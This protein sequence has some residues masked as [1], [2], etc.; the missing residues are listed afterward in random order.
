[1]STI[2]P[3]RILDNEVVTVS[4]TDT[5]KTCEHW[6]IHGKY[7]G[8]QVTKI[9]AITP[10][11]DKPATHQVLSTC[12]TRAPIKYVC[13]EHAAPFSR[14]SGSICIWCKHRCPRGVCYHRLISPL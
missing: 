11:C 2:T 13:D 6:V 7:E 4:D 8:T 9:T 5:P 14:F 10:D 1:M 3:S 12:C